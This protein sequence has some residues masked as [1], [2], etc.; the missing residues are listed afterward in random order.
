MARVL[1]ATFFSLLYYN[2][3]AIQTICDYKDLQKSI[4]N[5]GLGSILVFLAM[6][7]YGNDISL[8]SRFQ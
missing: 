7:Q 8:L 3:L 4:T 5:I 2:K 1:F 6:L